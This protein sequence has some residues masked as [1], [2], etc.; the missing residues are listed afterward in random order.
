MRIKIILYNLF[1]VNYYITFKIKAS[2]KNAI[3]KKM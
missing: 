1:P 3:R 2:S